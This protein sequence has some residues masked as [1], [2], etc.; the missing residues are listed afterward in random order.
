MSWLAAALGAAAMGAIGYAHGKL[1]DHD[2]QLRVLQYQ[3]AVQ[4]KRL[5]QIDTKLDRI[6]DRLPFGK[7][8]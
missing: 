8:P 3:D 6:L 5:D 4:E 7:P 1:W 2:G